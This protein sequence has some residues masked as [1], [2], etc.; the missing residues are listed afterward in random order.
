MEKINKA[1]CPVSFE[2]LL[3]ATQE[4]NEYVGCGNPNAS[5]LII[6]SE[7]AIATDEERYKW[8]MAENN[9]K[10]LTE[11]VAET[12]VHDGVIDD[13]SKFSPRF[14]YKGQKYSVRSEVKK[15]E[16]THIRSV[17]GTSKTWYNYQKLLDLVRGVNRSKADLLDF[18][19]WCFTSELNTCCAKKS[20][21]VDEEGRRSSI[22]K[23]AGKSNRFFSSDFFQGFPIVIVAS[24]NYVHRYRDVFSVGELFG[25]PADGK[26]VMSVPTS[27]G[28]RNRHL[29]I[30]SRQ[31]DSPKL[32]I[33]CSHFANRMSEEYMKAIASTIRE[34]CAENKIQI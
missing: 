5:I 31:G 24:R 13:I 9:K 10:W 27:K 7:P 32:L 1:S 12:I 17:A 29:D 2:Q 23:R 34:F 14:P 16:V 4:N 3:K 20:S 26:R 19:D 33:C 8:E 30:Y 21:E 25:F 6:A 15:D 11:G 22:A 18:H 28:G